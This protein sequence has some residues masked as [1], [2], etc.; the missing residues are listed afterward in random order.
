MIIYNCT[1]SIL[2]QKIRIILSADNLTLKIQKKAHFLFVINLITKSKKI[3]RLGRSLKICETIHL[4]TIWMT[5]HSVAGADDCIHTLSSCHI[6]TIYKTKTAVVFFC[7]CFHIYFILKPKVSVQ[8]MVSEVITFI[9]LSYCVHNSPYEQAVLAVL[10]SINAPCSLTIKHFT[11]QCVICCNKSSSVGLLKVLS[12][13][14]L[15]ILFSGWHGLPFFMNPCFPLK[16][17]NCIY[18][19]RNCIAISVLSFQKCYPNCLYCIHWYDKVDV[20]TTLT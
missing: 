4:P 6:L 7:L 20:L 2:S 13:L 17:L 12:G 10:L 5:R 9:M 3:C 8:I 14:G 15:N 16:F 18:G 19:T 1:W 11:R